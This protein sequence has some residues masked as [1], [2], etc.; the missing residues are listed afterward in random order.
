MRSVSE[1][2]PRSENGV[3]LRVERQFRHNCYS[4]TKTSKDRLVPVPS[5]VA[6]ALQEHMLQF[7][8]SLTRDGTIFSTPSGTPLHY[9]NFRN[10]VWNPALESLGLGHRGTHA[11]RHTFATLALDKGIDV[12]TVTDWGGWSDVK[13]VLNVYRGKSDPA[14]LQAAARLMAQPLN[15]AS[16]AEGGQAA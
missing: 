14:K 4:E 5:N 2:Q 3:M 12:A 8:P 1:A 10:R 16:D 11:L 13:M 15:K 6:V 7:P 9:D